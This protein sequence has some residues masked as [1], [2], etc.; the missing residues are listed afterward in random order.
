M[1]EKGS[2]ISEFKPWGRW[3]TLGLGLIALFGGQIVALIVLIRWFGFSLPRWSD[4]VT[5]GV[6]VTVSVCIAT[7]VQVALLVLMAWRTGAGAT[8][9]LG[10]TVPPKRDLLLGI[11]AV[12]ILTAAADGVSWILGYNLVSQFQLDIYNSASAAGWLPWL[13]LTLVVVAPIGEE[14]LF[15]GFLFR[16][17]HRTSRDS[18]AV[19]I[20]TALLWA[21]THVQYNPYFMAQVFGIGLMFGWFRYKSG[22]TIL[23]MVLHGLVN[24]EG[25]VETVWAIHG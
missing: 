6:L 21:L 7:T 8:A 25:T 13:L 16:G 10:L 15:R 23:T 19:I 11:I 20:I 9:Y 22:S 4:L 24:L 18:W 2:M 17:W 5:D 1:R 3:A 12:A 14:T